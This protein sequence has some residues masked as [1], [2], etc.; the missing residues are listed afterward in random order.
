MPTFKQINE[1]IEALVPK[2]HAELI[3]MER[4]ATR[5]SFPIIGPACGHLCY[6]LTRTIGAR[7]VFEMGSGYGYSTAFFARGVQENGG[8]T[9]HHVVWDEDLSAR[10]RK[11]L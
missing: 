5:T 8:G 1:Y 2:R 3:R 6:Q 4:I 10:A 9:V 11:H 7:Q